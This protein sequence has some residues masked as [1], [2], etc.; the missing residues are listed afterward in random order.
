MTDQTAKPEK[1]HNLVKSLH[2]Q[3]VGM[4]ALCAVFCHFQ[5]CYMVQV[6]LMFALANLHSKQPVTDKHT[7]L[8][9]TLPQI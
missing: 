4:I 8:H 9:Q 2:A 1:R 3:V 6:Q 7:L 5:Q